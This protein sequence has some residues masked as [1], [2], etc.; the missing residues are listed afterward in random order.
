[1]ELRALGQSRVFN[2]ADVAEAKERA[3]QRRLARL[4]LFLAVLCLYFW[5]RLVQGRP[6]QGTFIVGTIPGPPPGTYARLRRGLRRWLDDAQAAG[7]DEE[8]IAAFVASTLRDAI[9]GEARA[10]A[11]P[12]QTGSPARTHSVAILKAPIP[13]P[14]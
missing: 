9:E 12:C 13:A 14:G 10:G 4:T 2:G 3:R 11:A 8:S 6:G 5:V 1:M 7:L